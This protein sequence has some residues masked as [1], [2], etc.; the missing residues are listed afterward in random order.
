MIAELSGFLGRIPASLWT[1]L[2]VALGAYIYWRF[3]DKTEHRRVLLDELGTFVV[4]DII[5]TRLSLLLLYPSAVLHLSIWTFFSE[6]PAAGWV[7]GMVVA[8]L[9]SGFSLRKRHQA[10][11]ANL[12]SILT[13]MTFGAILY[14]AY[15][16]WTSY[17]P[18]KF[19][20]EVRLGL[21][22]LLAI[23]LW[24]RRS[25]SIRYP[26]RVFGVQGAL[27]LATSAM[28]P[29]LDKVGPLGTA[30]WGFSS[31]IGLA[32]LV[33]ATRDWRLRNRV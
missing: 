25:R 24:Q 20:A 28:V 5:V 7:L 4:I 30:Q 19:Q 21:S 2:L 13:A 3:F 15:A 1:I 10:T 11:R 23:W 9:Y 22:V 16:T 32:V 29:H 31:V 17:P 26:E 8:A 33:E 14:F 18:F 6:P 12:Q 27:L